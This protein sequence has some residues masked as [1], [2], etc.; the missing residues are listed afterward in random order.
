VTEI[1]GPN[2]SPM[3]RRYLEDVL[4]TMGEHVD[5]EG[6]RSAAVADVGWAGAERHAS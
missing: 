2:Y 4:E 3:R 5:I 6:A 1:R